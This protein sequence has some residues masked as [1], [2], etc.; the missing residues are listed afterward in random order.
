MAM[1]QSI[2]Q[3]ETLPR[4]SEQAL[5][6]AQARVH[7][8][9][10]Q[11]RTPQ[12]PPEANWLTWLILSGRGWG[13]TRTGAEWIVWEAIRQPKTRWAVIAKTHADIRD[14][15]FEGESGIISVLKRYNI[16]TEKSYNRSNY[17]YMLPNGSRIKGFSA[18]EPDRLRGPQHHGGWLDE[19]AAWE[20]PEAYDQYKFGLRL[21]NNP[22]SVI[23]TTPRPT[24]LIKELIADDNTH[25]TR[26][27]TFDNSANLAASALLELQRKYADTR[28]GQQELYGAILDDNPGALWS[29]AMIES[30]RVTTTPPFVRV[31]VG[32]DPAVTSGEDSDYTG[33]VTAGM[34]SDGHYYI[35]SD[36][37]IKSSP[38]EWAM[39]AIQS[40]EAHKADR[41]IA[42]TNNGGDL[43]LH[44][45]QQVNST[46]PVRKVT[47]TRGKQVRAEPI[48]ALYEQG[49]VH[50]VGYFAELEDQMC[51]YEP[52][53][54]SKSPDRMDALVWALTDLSEGSASMNFLASLATFCPACRIPVPKSSNFCPK[55]NTAIGETN[56]ISSNQPNS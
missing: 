2:E 20:K 31:V 37:T 19:L 6:I 47:A 17:S 28:L 13:K 18:E 46:I 24:K 49:R 7:W 15:C 55:C 38:Q 11:A 50:H 25:V 21:G 40:F 42:E 53:V 41:I 54:T 30:A 44:L 14:T 34:S 48:A 1:T 56:A 43:V 3:S 9:E 36:D 39:K 23:T 35:L 4:Y 32:V 5:Q 12:L 10:V 16:F 27:S 52:G 45:F 51:E 26:G 29:R 8:Q 33:I 22:K